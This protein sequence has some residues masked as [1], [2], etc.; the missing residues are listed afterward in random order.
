MKLPLGAKYRRSQWVK[1]GKPQIED[2]NSASPS[3]ADMPSEVSADWVTRA[4]VAARPR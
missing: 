2:N 1:I 4:I 3:K